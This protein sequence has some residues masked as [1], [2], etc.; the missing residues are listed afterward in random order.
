MYLEHFIIDGGGKVGV[1]DDSFLD[2]PMADEV[3][4]QLLANNTVAGWYQWR[5]GKQTDPTVTPTVHYDRFYWN[6]FQDD[7]GNVSFGRFDAWFRT[8]NPKAIRIRCVVEGVLGRK[9][10]VFVPHGTIASG[11][12]VPYWNHPQF[13]LKLNSFLQQFATLLEDAQIPLAWVEIGIYGNYGEW[14]LSGLTGAPEASAEAK[15]GII[16]AHLV[17]FNEL[18]EIKLMSDAGVDWL[19]YANTQITRSDYRWA[20]SKIVGFRR[21]SLGTPHFNKI[22][23]DP[24]WAEIASKSATVVEMGTKQPSLALALSQVLQYRVAWVGNGNYKSWATMSMDEQVLWRDLGAATQHMHRLVGLRI[25]NRDKAGSLCAH[26]RFLSDDHNLPTAPLYCRLQIMGV[27][28]PSEQELPEQLLLYYSYIS[29]NGEAE[30]LVGTSWT[31]V[32]DDYPT[33]TGTVELRAH[34]PHAPLMASYSFTANLVFMR[35][36]YQR[37]LEREREKVRALQGQ[38]E[39]QGNYISHIRERW[40]AERALVQTTLASYAEAIQQ[41][42]TKLS[43]TSQALGAISFDSMP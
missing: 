19:R 24:Y 32:T 38:V 28:N 6:D 21:D 8:P 20:V 39:G 37:L 40:R 26:Q 15:Q 23:A 11:E 1:V 4:A 14:H 17:A 43:E 33:V 25:G 7:E 35:E 16:D 29:H 3:A 41:S 5:Q 27:P 12:T 31:W 34:S 42:T 2:L 22:D 30:P 18:A 36:D 13:L 10:P 9:V